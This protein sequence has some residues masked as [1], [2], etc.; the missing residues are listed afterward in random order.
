VVVVM[1]MAPPSRAALS[2]RCQRLARVT[3][4]DSGVR[5]APRTLPP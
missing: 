3:A 1:V 2:P 4:G 5:V